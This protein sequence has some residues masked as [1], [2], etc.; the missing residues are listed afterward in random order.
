MKRR[1]V[2]KVQPVE[3]I[4]KTT[5]MMQVQTTMI[6][7]LRNPMQHLQQQEM[8]KSHLHLMRKLKD[9]ETKKK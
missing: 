5:R 6:K 1:L 8:P 7:R 4:A 2:R 9:P 3:M